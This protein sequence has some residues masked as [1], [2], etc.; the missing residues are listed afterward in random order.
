PSTSGL[1]RPP[2]PSDE[3]PQPRITAYTRRS[4]RVAS[5]CLINT[6]KPQPSPGQKPCECWSYTRISPAARAAFLAKPTSSNG[7]RL[8]STPPARATSRSPAAR[9]EQAVDTASKEEAQAPSTVYPPP[10]MPY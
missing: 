9:P 10:F 1:V 5:A 4:C 2:C 3:T 7:S 6:K 8:R